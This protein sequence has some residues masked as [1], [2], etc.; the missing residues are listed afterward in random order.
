MNY[1]PLKNRNQIGTQ[2]TKKE[3]SYR[4]MSTEEYGRNSGGEKS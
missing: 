2:S 4:R 1:K 3:G